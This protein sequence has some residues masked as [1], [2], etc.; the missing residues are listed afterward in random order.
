[1]TR[2]LLIS[3]IAALLA[4]GCLFGPEIHCDDAEWEPGMTC[5]AVLA[6][7]QA[8][9]ADQPPITRLTAVQGMHCPDAP[10]SCPFTS[11]VVA[12]YADTA[13]GDRLYVNVALLDDGTLLA[14]PPGRVEQDR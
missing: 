10:A 1:V 4:S 14:Q 13:G 3:A 8:E 6:A 12:V 11:L 5:D 2:A 7:A 9:L